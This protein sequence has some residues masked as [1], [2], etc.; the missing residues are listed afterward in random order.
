[1]SARYLL[2]IDVE[3]SGRNVETNFMPAFGACVVD[4]E[5]KRV[6]NE[7][8]AYLEQP[9]GTEWEQRCLDEFWNNANYGK[10]GKT[11]MQLLVEAR[12]R[13]GTEPCEAAI[14]RFVDWA[15]SMSKRYKDEL[16]VVSDTAAFDTTWMNVYLS[17]YNRPNQCVSLLY[18][19]GEYRPVRDVSSFYHGAAG[20]LQAW[21]GAK[22]VM[23]RVQG[24]NEWPA[25][26]TAVEA[27]HNPLNDAKHIGLQAVH[28][29]R[30]LRGDVSS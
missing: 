4:V 9:P 11:Q 5:E 8:L 13:H 20:R 16:L 3:A 7:F 10:D 19:T 15:Q 24:S 23:E 17:K 2:A 21:G 27:D 18:L 29:V 22:R 28:V 1:M 6:V 25:W 30:I 14:R 26:V 12:E